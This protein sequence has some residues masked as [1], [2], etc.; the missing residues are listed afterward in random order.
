VNERGER[1]E[2]VVIGIGN[3]MRGDDGLGPAAVAEMAKTGIGATIE[4][5]ALDGEA[6]RLIDTWRDRHLAVVVDAIVGGDTPGTIHRVEAGID[7]LPHRSSGP[8]SHA[9]GVAEAVAL[10]R[11]LDRLP[12]RLMIFG[13]EPADLG[14]GPSLS[15]D[16]RAALPELI[17]LIRHE[18]GLAGR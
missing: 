12:Q 7:D 1:A 15:V 6:T 18:V 10:G 2:V 13:V 3:D 4:L 9:A 8:S 16:V 11:A 5:V 17:E 14:P